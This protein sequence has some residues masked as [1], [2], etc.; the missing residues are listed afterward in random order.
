MIMENGLK[1]KFYGLPMNGIIINDHQTNSLY[2][3]KELGK[4]QPEDSN[5]LLM[6]VDTDADPTTKPLKISW[7]II[8][9]A[10]DRVGE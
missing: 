6:K 10:M 3:F 2:S 9:R 8:G 5:A 7:L 4:L 1:I